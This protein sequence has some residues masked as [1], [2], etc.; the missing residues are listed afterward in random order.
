MNKKKTGGRKEQ[1][2]ETKKKIYETA[3]RLFK[4]NGFDNV[5]V[6]SIVEAAGVSKGSFYVHFHSKGSLITALGADLVAKVDSEYKSYF[7]SSLSEKK[8]TDLLILFAEKIAEVIAHTL[9]YDL[10]KCTYQAQLTRTINLES[11]LSYNRDVYQIFEK[12]ISR[13][14]QQGEFRHDLDIG[15]VANHCVMSIRGLTFEWCIRYPDFNLTDQVVKHFEI[16][17]SGL[18]KQQPV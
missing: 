16:L 8:A 13:G 11:T 2:I 3:G 4:K 14:I 10:I 6:D 1:A 7:E 18:R 17:L 9:G 12:I 15:T 5:S